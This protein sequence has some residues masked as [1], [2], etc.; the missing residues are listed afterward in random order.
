MKKFT[1][2]GLITALITPFKKDGSVDFNALKKLIDY[3]VENKA[4][5]IV[6]CGSTGESATLTTRDKQAI[7]IQAV[8]YS[9][10]RIPV[11]AGTG[12]N[13]TQ[14]TL[15]MSIFAKEHGADAILLV[16]PYY[17]KPT[18][19]GLYEHYHLIANNVDIPQIIYNVPGRTGV[20]IKPET[21]KKLADTCPNI[22]AIKE[23]SGNME[24]IMEI[25]HITNDG[26]AVLSGD[27]YLAIPV[28]SIGGKG[29]ISVI[30]NYAA[31][32]F[33]GCIH[34]AMDGKLKE[35][36]K[37]HY[38]LLELMDLNF[39]ESNPIPVKYAVSLLGMCKEVYRLPM[40]PLLPDNKKKIKASMI[41]AGIIG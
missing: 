41:A 22:V 12:T 20:N 23:S 17:N 35:A 11:I 40:T 25:I 37:L 26:F 7:I 34:A 10:G 19:E 28:I 13:E 24:Q 39:I 4:D 16:T 6:V 27:D 15:D 18:Q 14:F 21:V 38:D 29:I 8:E 1:P 33:A 2:H 32:Q 31:G 30:S 5:A 36:R 9:A 3:Q